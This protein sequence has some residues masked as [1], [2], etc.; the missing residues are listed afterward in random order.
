MRSKDKLEDEARAVYDV[1]SHAISSISRN[2]NVDKLKS[3]LAE[4]SGTCSEAVSYGRKGL[5]S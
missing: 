5:V 2:L 3:R 4:S 1:N